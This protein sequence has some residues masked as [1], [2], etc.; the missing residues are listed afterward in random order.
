MNIFRQQGNTAVVMRKLNSIIPTL[1][2]LELPAIFRNICKEKTG[3]VLVTGA[4]GSGKTTTLAAIINEVL[5]D[6]TQAVHIVTLEDPIEFHHPHQYSTINQ[7]EMGIDFDVY[8]QGLRAALRQAPKVILIGEMRDRATVDIALT[9]AETG[10]LVLSTLHTIDAGQ[11]IGRILGMFDLDEAKQIRQRL[12]DTMR[13]V[14]SQRLVPRT[15]GGRQLILEVLGHNLRTKEAIMLGE[16]EGR[17]F[18][19]IIEAS[20]TFG[21]MTFDHSLL[22]AYKAELITEDTANLYATKKGVV[23]R[24]I[25][26]LKKSRGSELDEASGLKIDALAATRR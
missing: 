13:Y 23:T 20:E 18:Y 5:P 12:S 3:L 14:V 16:E 6:R 8:P 9:A 1:E 4:T 25:D 2:D 15:D 21:W 10:H 17:T 11:S 7:R 19:D 24:A 26:L 22:N